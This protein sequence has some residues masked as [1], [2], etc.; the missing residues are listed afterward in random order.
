M[1]VFF[2]S[3]LSTNQIGKLL[4]RGIV[5]VVI[6]LIKTVPVPFSVEEIKNFQP[7]F[8]VFSSK[9]GV[10]HFL[11]RIPVDYLKKTRVI[12]V[13]KSTANILKNAGIKPL[14]PR[15]Y[16]GEGLVELVKDLSI[17]G[18]TFLLIKPKVARKILPQFLKE[19]GNKVK[20][21]VV[22]E[23]VTN[24]EAGESLVEE[25]RKGFEILTFTSPSTFKSF[26]KL[27]GNDGRNLLLKS[28]I[29]PIGHVTA[30]TI[31]K[32]GFNVWKIPEEYTLDGIIDTITGNLNHGGQN[33]NG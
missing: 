30:E 31:R 23:T 29:V 3:K 15:S 21:L 32:S 22:Y 7:D 6:P 17:T 27:S 33:D 19:S 9:N 16:S 5:P 14:I 26:L 13:G 10:R 18:K 11:S 28:K 8:I 1:R 20:E 4:D 25:I 24:R 2:P 12:A